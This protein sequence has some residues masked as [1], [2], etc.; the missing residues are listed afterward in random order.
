MSER[1]AE[2][3]IQA[4][5]TPEEKEDCVLAKLFVSGWHFK[6]VHSPE[7]EIIGTKIHYVISADAGGNIP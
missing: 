5:L 4:N 2:E 7:G 1:G 6:P 3:L